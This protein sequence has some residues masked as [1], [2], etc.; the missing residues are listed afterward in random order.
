[1]PSFAM[2]VRSE[3]IYPD[4]ASAECLEGEVTVGFTIGPGGTPTDLVILK[5]EP[6]GYFE[7]ATLKNVAKWQL[8][9]P[10]G[11]VKEQ[12]IQFRIADIERCTP[13]K[14]GEPEGFQPAPQDGHNY[15]LKPT[16]SPRVS[17][18]RCRP[19]AA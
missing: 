1:M 9:E 10:E 7:E 12:T 5:A 4:R 18:N 8:S 13:S 6:P 11:T 15:V 2:S 19:A 17:T 16:G 14:A 3:A